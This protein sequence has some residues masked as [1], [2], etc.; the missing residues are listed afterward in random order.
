M[1]VNVNAGITF[2]LLSTSFIG[3]VQTDDNK[4][5]VLLLPSPPVQKQGIT[6][7][8][9]IEDFKSFASNASK[10]KAPQEDE[11]KEMQEKMEIAVRGFSQENAKINPLDIVIKIEEAFIYYYK[12]LKS[13]SVEF[14]YAF[15]ISLD[16]SNLIKEMEAFKLENISLSIWNTERPGILNEMKM[17]SIS[18]YL[19][20]YPKLI[21]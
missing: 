14:E 5:S 2:T 3:A 6:I 16:M 4:I 9:M 20:Q 15:S 7:R 19:D 13:G 10:G 18:S 1:S 11:A 17:Q 21:G 12:D 8:K